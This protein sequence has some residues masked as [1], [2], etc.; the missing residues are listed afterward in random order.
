LGNGDGTFDPAENYT[1]G[2]SPSSVTLGDLNRDGI[3]DIITANYSSSNA[4]VLL[5]NGDGTFDPAENYTTGNSPSSVTLGDLNRDGILDIITANESSGKVSVL[6]GNANGTFGTAVNHFTGGAP[7]APSSVTLGDVNG[8]GVLDIITAERNSD[9]ASVLLGNGMFPGDFGSATNFATGDAPSSVTLGDVN[10]D[11]KLD[12]ITA[13][14]G[15]DTSSVLL[16]NGDGTFAA[17]ATFATGDA[18]KSVTLGDVNGDGRLDIISANFI[19]SNASVLLGT[20]GS[21]I[22]ATFLLLTQIPP[23]RHGN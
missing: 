4:S 9:T 5:G 22:Y 19:S 7:S 10:G 23:P 11:G 3:L 6:L 12:I 13:N 2:N 17:Q 16:G 1:T 21:A 15:F 20:G 8:D 14:E 18:P